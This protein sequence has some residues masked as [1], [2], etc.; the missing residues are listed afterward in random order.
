MKTRRMV[1]FIGPTQTASSDQ[2]RFHQSPSHQSSFNTMID[3]MITMFAEEDMRATH[4][5]VQDMV[6]RLQQPSISGASVTSPS[7]G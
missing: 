3:R 1:L 2:L 6:L 5:Q 4:D 7:P